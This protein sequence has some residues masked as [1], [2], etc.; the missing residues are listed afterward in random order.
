MKKWKICL[1]TI[2]AV[3]VLPVIAVGIWQRDNI[4][5]VVKMVTSSSD[6]IAKEMNDTKKKLEDDL[7]KQNINVVSDFTA[8]EEKQI[9]KGKLSV[10]EAVATLT[11]KYKSS[12]NNT[13]SNNSSQ[14]DKLIGEKTVELYSLKAYYLGQLGQME[15]R[16]KSE[17][18]SL[19]DEK[20][21]VIGKKDIVNRHMSTAVGL[22]NQCDARVE[23]ILAELK[24]GLESLKADTSIIKT[25]RSAYENEKNLKKAYYLSLL[26]E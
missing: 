25:I 14:V 16:V 7:K 15:S 17:Y 11:E 10:E 19:P 26:D 5:A 6:E 3:L 18:A 2:L 23:K 12:Q 13:S 20:K 4:G 21:N 24:S 9:L 8:E 1:L 22:M